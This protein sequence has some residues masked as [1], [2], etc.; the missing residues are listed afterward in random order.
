M[1]FSNFVQ[2]FSKSTM[3]PGIRETLHTPRV[4]VLADEKKITV[5]GHS[6]LEDPSSFY[7]E[8]ITLLDECMND[9]KTHATI[10][11]S[12]SY[13]NSSSSK[14][15]F[16]I[17]KNMQNKY[18]GKKLLTINW[19]Y[20]KDDDAILEAGEVFQSLLSLPFNIIPLN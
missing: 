5:K 13:L 19:Y 17:L 7:E 6:R 16:H 2:F 1:K 8:F 3:M 9:F 15:L 10:D 18:Q 11:F 14:W 12:F 20:E 4:R